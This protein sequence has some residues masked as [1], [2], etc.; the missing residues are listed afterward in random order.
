MAASTAG[1][2]G[3]PPPPVEPQPSKVES[4]KNTHANMN[5]PGAAVRGSRRPVA[6]RRE[7]F[8]VIAAWS[9]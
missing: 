6:L 2:E 7:P 9:F 5:C 8:G 4:T 1:P 3:P